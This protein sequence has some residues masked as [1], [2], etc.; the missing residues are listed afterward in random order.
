MWFAFCIEQNVPWL[1]VPMKNPVLM[2]VMNSASDLRDQFSRLSDRHRLALDYLVELAA[3]D[4]FHAEV[5]GAVALADFV[6]RN[7]SRMFETSGGFGFPAKTLQVRF[8]R[9]QTKANH[10]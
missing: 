4:E 1:D 10:F 6:D 3:F 2:R 8:A 7:N 5:A 9:P